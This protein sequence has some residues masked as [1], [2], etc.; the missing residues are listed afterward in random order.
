MLTLKIY[1]LKYDAE[2]KDEF[3]L[4][5]AFFKEVSI[6][7]INDVTITHSKDLVVIEAEGKIFILGEIHE[8][9]GED[10]VSCVDY[11][12]VIENSNGKT[13][14]ILKTNRSLDGWYDK[15]KE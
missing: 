9:D 6:Y 11:R 4:E 13:T 8:I 7:D 2:I 12:A 10:N 1:K 14:E 5:D 15:L 3:E